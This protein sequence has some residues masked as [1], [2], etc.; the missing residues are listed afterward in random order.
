MLFQQD[1]L[2]SAE[3]MLK[4]AVA[5]GAGRR[6]RAGNPGHRV[7][8][9]APVRRGHAFP[10]DRVAARS[11]KTPTAHNYLGITAS[12]KGYAEAA[13][14]ELQKAIALNPNYADAHFNLAVVFATKQPPDKARA[15][16]H[17]NAA[18][19]L[20]ASPDPTLEKLIGN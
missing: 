1:K 19:R 12:Q 10:D 16:E 4:K 20:G 8:P 15:R 7:L 13:E 2:K 3:V 17:Y 14:D 9:D 6:L 11:R 18:V 5:V